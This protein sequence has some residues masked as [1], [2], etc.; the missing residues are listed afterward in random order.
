MMSLT[1]VIGFLYLRSLDYEAELK[2][3]V[4]INLKAA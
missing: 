2:G 4:T 1:H 3:N